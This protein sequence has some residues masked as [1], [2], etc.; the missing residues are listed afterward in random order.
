MMP[1]AVKLC[2]LAGLWDD[3][4][5][6]PIRSPA[7]IT[8]AR[9]ALWYVLPGIG[10]ILNRERPIAPLMKALIEVVAMSSFCVRIGLH[11]RQRATLKKCYGEIYALFNEYVNSMEEDVQEMLKYLQGPTER[12]TILY[13]CATMAGVPMYGGVAGLIAI[14]KTIVG[15]EQDLP[16]TCMEAE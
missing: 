11:V 1:L 15:L 7:V 16:A 3:T 5:S 10:F 2:K 14:C 4:D 12:L 6:S 13:F 8:V 9:L